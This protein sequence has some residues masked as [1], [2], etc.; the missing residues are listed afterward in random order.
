MTCTVCGDDHKHR[1][2]VDNSAPWEPGDYRVCNE[3]GDV[4][5]MP[6]HP[7]NPV[8]AQIRDLEAASADH[9]APANGSNGTCDQHDLNGIGRCTLPSGHEGMHRYRDAGNG[10]DKPPA[11]E[12]MPGLLDSKR[13][14]DLEAAAHPEPSRG[15]PE[16]R[17]GWREL[18]ERGFYNGK[19][20]YTCRRD[21]LTTAPGVVF[22]N[23][24]DHGWDACRAAHGFGEDFDAAM[25]CAERL[26]PASERAVSEPPAGGVLPA[27][28][29]GTKCERCGQSSGELIMHPERKLCLACRS[30]LRALEVLKNALTHARSWHP[31][32]LAFGG[33][34]SAEVRHGDFAWALELALATIDG[35]PLTA[36]ELGSGCGDPHCCLPEYNRGYQNGFAAKLAAPSPVETSSPAPATSVPPPEPGPTLS[37]LDRCHHCDEQYCD[38]IDLD[39]LAVHIECDAKAERILSEPA[40][41]VR[42]QVGSTRKGEPAEVDG[43]ST[44]HSAAKASTDRANTGDNVGVRGPVAADSRERPAPSIA[45]QTAGAVTALDPD[46]HAALMAL[47]EELPHALATLSYGEQHLPQ[48]LRVREAYTAV[49]DAL[50]SRGQP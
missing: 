27:D 40:Q 39:G 15:E 44:A 13:V 25:R 22:W 46:V 10:A 18:R 48:W 47:F 38:A 9:P 20:Q 19:P 50:A 23:D 14:T 37:N 35:E 49:Y 42:S 31:E 43:S 29:Q 11:V 32:T 36:R 24:V 41:P 7:T 28:K 30:V 34:T 2:P 6:E 5:W 8:I 12:T 45:A 21:L 3:S 17:D 1:K 16:L 33:G 4:R 26:C